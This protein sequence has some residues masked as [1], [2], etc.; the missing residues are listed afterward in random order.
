VLLSDA[1][2]LDSLGVVGVLRDFS[3]NAR[4]MRKA[5]A[6][7]RKRRA[8]LP[9]LLQLEGSKQIAAERIL[10]MDEL[11]GRFEQDTWGDF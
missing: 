10:Q 9:R 6:V 3:G 1:D 8:T 11:I 4:D 5:Y 2:A 7:A